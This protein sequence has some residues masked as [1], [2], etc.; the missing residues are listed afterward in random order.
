MHVIALVFA[1]VGGV[2]VLLGYFVPALKEVQ[3]LL[4]N[5]AVILAG[6]AAIVGVFNLILV[7]AGRIQK[8][9]KGA[10]YSAILIL[11]LFTAFVFGLMLGPD[12]PEMRRLVG[13]VIVPAESSL[14]ALLA[15]SLIAGG[16]RLLRRRANL[17]SIVFLATAVLVLLASATLPFGEIGAL[18]SLV[19]PWFQHVLGM[20]GARGILVGMALGTLVTGLRVLIGAHRPY[21]GG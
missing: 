10:G 16:I 15:V 13:A 17:M 4:L 1:L 21:E 3:Q 2:I 18:A 20:G 8:K 6:T 5:W 9:E 19:K 11:S 14:M 12:H 7:H